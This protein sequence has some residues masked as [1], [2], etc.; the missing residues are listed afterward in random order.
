M[1]D[2]KSQKQSN[3]VSDLTSTMT[4]LKSY[5]SLQIVKINCAEIKSNLDKCLQYISVC[6]SM[7]KFGNEETKSKIFTFTIKCLQTQ[8]RLLNIMHD[9]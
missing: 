7:N 1:I 9:I 8:L 6:L 2:N 5:I 3:Q 4:A